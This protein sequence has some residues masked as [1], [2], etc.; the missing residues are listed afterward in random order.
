MLQ[1]Q[2]RMSIFKYIEGQEVLIS[3]NTPDLVGLKVKIVA[4][5]RGPWRDGKTNT[6]SYKVNPLNVNL[7]PIEVYED[8]LEEIS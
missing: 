3:H 6:N 7:A 8:Q 1:N 2:V 4:R 5:F